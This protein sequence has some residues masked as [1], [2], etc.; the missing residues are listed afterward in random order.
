MIVAVASP[1]KRKMWAAARENGDFFVL[2]VRITGKLLNI[3][4]CEGFGKD[5]IVFPSMQ[6]IS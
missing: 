4:G 6:H 2:E 3:D 1:G 5:S